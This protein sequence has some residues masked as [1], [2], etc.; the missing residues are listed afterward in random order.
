[1]AYWILCVQE[2]L[3]QPEKKRPLILKSYGDTI[4]VFMNWYVS[5][6]KILFC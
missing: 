1:M 6:Y 5:K 4:P 2:S 3:M